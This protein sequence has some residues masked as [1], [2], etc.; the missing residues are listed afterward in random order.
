MA[1]NNRDQV[2]RP[3]FAPSYLDTEGRQHG[4][5]TCCDEL[6]GETLKHLNELE[7]Y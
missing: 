5:Q 1:A 6:D 4:L 3:I 7:L 2:H